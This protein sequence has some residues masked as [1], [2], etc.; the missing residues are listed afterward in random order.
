MGKKK[1]ERKK[2]RKKEREREKRKHKNHNKKIFTG[3]R[4]SGS[5]CKKY[6]RFNTVF[7]R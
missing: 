6:R 7:F 1:R 2:E 4:R 3:R 5:K